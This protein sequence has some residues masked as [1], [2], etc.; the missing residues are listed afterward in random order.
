MVAVGGKKQAKSR[1]CLHKITVMEDNTIIK[2]VCRLRRAVLR[3]GGAGC[4]I[5]KAQPGIKLCLPHYE[6]SKP[7]EGEDDESFA[8]G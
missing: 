1:V 4:Q 5:G 3:P 2:T 7:D 8:C 6:P